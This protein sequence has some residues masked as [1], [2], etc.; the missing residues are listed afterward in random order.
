ML[1]MNTQLETDLLLK[2]KKEESN[3]NDVLLIIGVRIQPI[4]FFYPAG[5]DSYLA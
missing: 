4:I 2:P 5:I 1:I 3:G